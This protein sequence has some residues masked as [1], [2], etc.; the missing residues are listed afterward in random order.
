MNNEQHF[1]LVKDR[2]EVDITSFW[3]L[4]TQDTAPCNSPKNL[5]RLTRHKPYLSM[6]LSSS[7]YD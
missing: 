4:K 3:V 7:R 5:Q 2:N 1:T 6:G